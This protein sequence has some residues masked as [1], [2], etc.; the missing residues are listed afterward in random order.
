M[1]SANLAGGSATIP[2]IWYWAS[3]GSGLYFQVNDHGTRNVEFVT[4]SGAVR[5]LTHGAHMLGLDS[6]SRNGVGAGTVS[7]T[8][9]PPEVAR[10]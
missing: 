3:D 1:T 9:H 7:Q 8:E 6:V 5:Q 2:A 10:S 4:T